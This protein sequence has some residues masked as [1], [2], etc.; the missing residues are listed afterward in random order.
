MDF[1][2]TVCKPV[3]PLVLSLS[4][5]INLF[6]LSKMRS[7]NALPVKKKTSKKKLRWFS[8][9][10]IEAEGKTLVR[11]RKEKIYGRICLNFIW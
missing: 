8:Y 9:F 6:C 4:V 7:V 3:M 5:K 2:A 11:K 10:I 1:G